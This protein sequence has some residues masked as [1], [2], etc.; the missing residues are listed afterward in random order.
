MLSLSFPLLSNHI[1]SEDENKFV[2]GH[3]Y[4]SVQN[5]IIQPINQK[6]TL[7]TQ[8]D[9]YIHSATNLK[10]LNYFDQSSDPLCIVYW[11]SLLDHPEE[12]EIGRT[13]PILKTT[14]PVWKLQKFV[15]KYPIDR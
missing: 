3:L 2:G 9:L 1:L 4:F 8:A 12:M 5:I 14:H 13:I 10:G 11:K 6:I 15:I 7:Y